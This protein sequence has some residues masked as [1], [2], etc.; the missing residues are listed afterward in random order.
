MKQHIPLPLSNRFANM[1]FVC[2]CLV[3]AIHVPDRVQPGGG[4]CLVGK[5]TF[6]VRDFL[7]CGALFLFHGG[8]FSGWPCRGGRLVAA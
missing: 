8:L 7:C 4:H 6:P 1:G 2:A 3:V 5:A